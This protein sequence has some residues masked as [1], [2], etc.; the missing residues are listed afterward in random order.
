M[1]QDKDNFPKSQ[2]ENHN[3]NP[4]EEG[5]AEEIKNYLKDTKFKTLDYL[6]QEEQDF[7]IQKIRD[8]STSQ[9]K[10]KLEEITVNFQNM[11]GDDFKYCPYC[12]RAMGGKH[13][14]YCKNPGHSIILTQLTK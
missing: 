4:T 1:N 7:L 11:Y 3:P 9:M 6:S 12:G 2:F 5:G 14:H 13:A 10:K 8:F